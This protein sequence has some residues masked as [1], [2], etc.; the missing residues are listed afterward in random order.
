MKRATTNHKIKAYMI[1]NQYYQKRNNK[2]LMKISKFCLG[3]SKFLKGL[4]KRIEK[5]ESGKIESGDLHCST[6]KSHKTYT[7]TTQ[8]IS[9]LDSFESIPHGSYNSSI[10]SV[11]QN[12]L[13]ASKQITGDVITV[14][15]I[16]KQITTEEMTTEE[17]I[18]GGLTTEV[19]V[20]ETIVEEVEGTLF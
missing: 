8:D 12:I 10:A 3:T 15:V 20:V 11:T 6:P 9:L 2:K 4:E 18:T 1:E 7:S 14:E 17:V 13:M 16:T 5:L 19:I